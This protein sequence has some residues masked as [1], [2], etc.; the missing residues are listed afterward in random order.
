M[1]AFKSR[2]LTKYMFAYWCL[3]DLL[4]AWMENEGVESVKGRT[5]VRCRE[6]VVG[7]TVLSK[8][9][10]R[11]PK[12]EMML[13]PTPIASQRGMQMTR[14]CR[15]VA[16]NENQKTRPVR[17]PKVE[18]RPETETALGLIGPPMPCKATAK[19]VQSDP[20][21]L[22]S[23]ITNSRDLLLINL[24]TYLLVQMVYGHFLTSLWQPI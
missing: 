17:V 5:A 13:R 2:N 10:I 19:N 8:Q 7:G 15:N 16:L 20:T 11:R 21:F 6:I 14:L 3:N 18:T 9:T 24:K 23:R 4:M 22:A 1:H 12:W